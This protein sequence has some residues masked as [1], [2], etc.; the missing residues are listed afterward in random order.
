MTSGIKIQSSMEKEMKIRSITFLSIFIALLV[1]ALVGCQ[2]AN[3]LDPL[4]SG[5]TSALKPQSAP[6][7]ATP[8]GGDLANTGNTVEDLTFIT[9][10][11]PLL[12][13]VSARTR[14][15]SGTISAVNGGT[16]N[17]KYS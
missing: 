2:T 9:L 1:L 17:L 12:W 16:V 6:S 15:A 13:P 10:P 14:T 11:R 3:P 4:N 5:E 7:E 8:P